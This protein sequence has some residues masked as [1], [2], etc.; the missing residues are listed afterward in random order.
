MTIEEYFGEWS[1]IV[2]LKDAKSVLTR[3]TSLKSVLCPQIKDVFK[4]FTICSLDKLRVV[5]IGQDPYMEFRNNEPVATGIAFANRADTPDRNLSPSLKVIKDSVI[6]F[7]LPHG[8]IIFDPSLEKWEEQGVLLINSALSCERGKAGSHSL[9]WRPF[10]RTFI[11]HLSRYK[12]G[13]VYVLMGSDA[14]TLEKFIAGGNHVLRV[15]HPAYYVRTGTPM[16]SD[17]WRKINLILDGQN[18]EKIK[19]FEEVSF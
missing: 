14:Q 7:T 18:G 11:T 13:V 1:K 12:T 16:P 10:M 8:N 6:D 3:L 4:A 19:W 2:N 9:I 15:H 5:I 17:L